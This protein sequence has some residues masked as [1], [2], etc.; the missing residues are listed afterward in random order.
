MC[1]P[2][3]FVRTEKACVS[4]FFMH[5]TALK[6]IILRS[7]LSDTELLQKTECS[8]KRQKEA[9]LELLE[10]LLE[11][12]QRRLYATFS[13]SSLWDY[14]HRGFHYS[15]MQNSEM[16]NTVKLMR[17]HPEAR[18]QIKQEEL[19]ITTASQ[20]QRFVNQEKK[21]GNT[22]SSE[23]TAEIL[24]ICKGLSKRE[25]EK[26]LFSFASE[27]VQALCKERIKTVDQNYTELKFLVTDSTLRVLSQVKDL[28][29]NEAL[30]EIFD[31]SIRVYL[32]AEKKK[33]GRTEKAAKKP[34]QE[35]PI[36][37]S[38]LPVKSEPRS[39]FISIEI[40]RA[41]AKRSGGQCEF[42]NPIT[43]VRCSSRFRLQL[44]HYPVPFC[45]GGENTAEGLRHL[46]QSHNL[47]SAMEAGI[48][49]EMGEVSKMV[50]EKSPLQ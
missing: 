44:D 25:V 17:A 26:T 6:K 43:S 47:R 36:Q 37:E 33:R 9:T 10:D 8:I 41:V 18:T 13:F 12:D 4:V 3:A 40:M 5:E 39:R 24:E 38:T 49:I 22:L 27:P 16:V 1:S 29:G 15:E 32:E 50:N 19:S 23:Q 31:Q 28:I 35:S 21:A 14:L 34:A 42:I 30:S 11:V 45:K 48:S 20:I 7:T 46:C 2:R